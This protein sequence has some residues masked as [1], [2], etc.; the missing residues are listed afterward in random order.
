MMMNL[1]IANIGTATGTTT[2]YLNNLHSTNRNG[3]LN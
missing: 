2:G 3:L 1:M